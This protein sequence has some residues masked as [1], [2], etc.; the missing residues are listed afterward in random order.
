MLNNNLI[1]RG[2]RKSLFIELTNFF[3]PYE[4]I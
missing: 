4:T 1:V 2:Y 3:F